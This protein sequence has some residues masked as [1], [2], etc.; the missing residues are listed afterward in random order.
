MGPGLHKRVWARLVS[1][2]FE[3]YR[4]TCFFVGMFFCFFYGQVFRCL[5]G[6]WKCT[7]GSKSVACLLF[8]YIVCTDVTCSDIMGEK[9]RERV[10]SAAL[11]RRFWPPERGVHWRRVQTM[12]S[13]TLVFYVNSHTFGVKRQAKWIFLLRLVSCK[14]FNCRR[15]ATCLWYCHPLLLIISYGYARRTFFF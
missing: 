7:L 13:F 3:L 15:S 14:G 12:Y 5:S 8:M 9:A 6:G 11:T 2:E 4:Q 10:A 1:Q